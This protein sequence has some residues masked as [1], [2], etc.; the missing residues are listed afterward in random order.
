LNPIVK[1]KIP[2]PCCKDNWINIAGGEVSCEKCGDETFFTDL[3]ITAAEIISAGGYDEP[4]K[5]GTIPDHDLEM[6]EFFKKCEK[7]KK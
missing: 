6:I 2:N 4:Q 1:K 5:D 7:E 3:G